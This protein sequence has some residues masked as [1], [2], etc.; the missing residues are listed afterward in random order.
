MEQKVR[1]KAV[2]NDQEKEKEDHADCLSWEGEGEEVDEHFS[3]VGEEE[4]HNYSQG[5]ADVVGDNDFS[6]ILTEFCEYDAIVE[7]LV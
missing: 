6:I 4:Q 5:G 2:E 7:G 3:Q 1:R